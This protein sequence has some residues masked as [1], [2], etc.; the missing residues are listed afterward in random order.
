MHRLISNSSLR[1]F[2]FGT[3]T[4]L[5]FAVSLVAFVLL[6]AAGLLLGDQ[7]IMQASMWLVPAVPVL[8]I[9][10]LLFGLR[11]RCPLCMNPPLVPRRCQKHRNARTLCGSHRFRVALAVLFTGKFTCPYCGEATRMEVRE[12]RWPM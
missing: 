5:L 10:Y 2:R 8:G 11:A 12:R 3:F 9:G 1:C 7:W 4:L 6:G